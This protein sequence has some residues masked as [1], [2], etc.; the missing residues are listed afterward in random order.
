MTDPQTQARESKSLQEK[1]G[2]RIGDYV[3]MNN[4][5]RIGYVASIIDYGTHVVYFI[6]LGK[7]IKFPCK[8]EWITK[9]DKNIYDG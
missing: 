3:R 8:R 6:E 5:G 7:I 1:D 2:I 4:D 9:L